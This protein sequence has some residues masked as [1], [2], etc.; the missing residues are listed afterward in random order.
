MKLPWFIVVLLTAIACRQNNQDATV[1]YDTIRPKTKKSENLKKPKQD[2]SSIEL[3]AFNK[4]SVDLKILEATTYDTS[5]FLNRFTTPEN[6]QLLKLS[7]ST[8]ELTFGMW[9]FDDSLLRKNALFNWLDHFGTNKTAIKWL[10]PTVLGKNHQLV[11]INDHSMIALSCVTK[12][13][14]R[15]WMNYQRFNFPGDS[16]RFVLT[17]SPQAKCK[18]FKVNSSNQL[19]KCHP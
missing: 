10:K 5:Y 6:R 13:N 2:S 17:A 12:M 8:S 3:T 14:P 15:A 18:W 1:D 9:K 11:I 7:S 16:L 19:I 4:D